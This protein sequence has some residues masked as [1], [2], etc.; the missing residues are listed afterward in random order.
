[1]L[2][3]DAAVGGTWARRYDRLHLH[4]IRQFSGLAHFP[5]P[6]R[7]PRYLSR[8]E[9]V[10]YLREYA[11]HFAL[12]VVGGTSVRRIRPSETGRGGWTVE[13][14]GE[15]WHGRAVVIATGQYRRPFIPPWPGRETYSGRLAHSVDVLERGAV[16]RSTRAGGRRRQQR[17]GDRDRSRRPRRRVGGDQRAHAAADRAA[18]S[19]RHAGPAHQ[20][21]AERAAGGDR[22]PAR[23]RHG[24]DRDRRSHT[25]RD[26][27]GDVRAVFDQAGAAHRRRLCRRA[28]A[29]TAHGEAGRR[30]PDARPASSSPAAPANRSTR[31]SRRP[32]SRRASSR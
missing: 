32:A 21:P 23:S 15:A 25:L 10:E 5:I 11:R 20:H 17:R 24:A 12:R 1:M 29:G 31:S 30:P 9:F 22:E 6:S 8:D 16:R 3:Q 26:A 19:V 28:E 7:Y 18:R 13:T 27:D 14:G 4:T 2:E